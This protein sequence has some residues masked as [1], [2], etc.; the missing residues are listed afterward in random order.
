MRRLFLALLLTV[1]SSL[2]FAGEP[3][4]VVKFINFSCPVC[5]SSELLDAPIRERVEGQ[6]GRFV[7]A[8][9]PRGRSDARERFYYALRELGPK[10]ELR[11]RQS[12][13]RGA[14]DMGYP[15]ADVPQTLDWLM[16]D[17]NTEGINWT[18]VLTD[19]NGTEPTAAVHRAVRLALRVGLQ[20]VPTYILVQG[21][22]VL[23]TLDPPSVG[24][25]LSQ[26]R[27]AVLKALQEHQTKP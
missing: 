6:G 11:V 26:L 27:T 10:M 18:N 22:E 19:V 25:E 13:Y 8:P 12:L 20:V 14:Q 16:I 17:L 23:A 7:V 2:A 15:L 9:L 24:G 3:I 1:S 5:R 21:D 4:H